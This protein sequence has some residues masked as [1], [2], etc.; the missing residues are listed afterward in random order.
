MSA[1][2]KVVPSKLP[3]VEPGLN[4]ENDETVN[5]PS[6]PSATERS[7][8]GQVGDEGN[9]PKLGPRFLKQRS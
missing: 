2:G 9:A 6:Q 5:F 8:G 4:P 1:I 3:N 7:S